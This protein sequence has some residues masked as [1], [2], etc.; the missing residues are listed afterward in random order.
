MQWGHLLEQQTNRASSSVKRESKEKGALLS[1]T[2]DSSQCTE[3]K[4]WKKKDSPANSFGSLWPL[5][6]HLGIGKLQ[7][8]ILRVKQWF[9]AKVWF[10]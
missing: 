9:V 1:H 3:S 6:L 8:R 2:Q 4:E 10:S 7:N 5:D